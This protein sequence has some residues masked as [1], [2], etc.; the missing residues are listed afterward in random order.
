MEDLK[1]KLIFRGYTIEEKLWK[2]F[3]VLCKVKDTNASQVIRDMIMDWVLKN[4]KH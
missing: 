3:A 4:Q 1:D 2:D